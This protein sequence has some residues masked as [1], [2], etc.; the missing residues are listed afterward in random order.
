MNLRAASTATPAKV[1]PT[2][3]SRATVWRIFRRLLDGGYLRSSGPDTLLGRVT[4]EHAQR[5]MPKEAEPW[6]RRKIAKLRRLVK[7]VESRQLET[8]LAT[9]EIFPRSLLSEYHG[10]VPKSV[11]TQFIS[12][13]QLKAKIQSVFNDDCV[14]GS[15]DLFAENI[16]AFGGADFQTRFNE[17]TNA[18]TA[19]LS[20]LEMLSR[21]VAARA[22]RQ[23]LG[24][25][26]NWPEPEQ[27]E[28]DGDLA[29]RAI[30]RLFQAVLFR[31]PTASERQQAVQLLRNINEMETLIS[32]RDSELAFELSVTDPET[33]LQSRQTI[34]IRVNGDRTGLTQS[35]IDQRLTSTD[36]SWVWNRVFRPLVTQLANRIL[37][38]DKASTLAHRDIGRV[39]LGRD[40]AARLVIHNKGTLRN[41]SFAGVEL[42]SAGGFGPQ[43]I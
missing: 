42:L 24:P 30:D 38:A 26:E 14:R 3:Y 6:N 18:T 43:N 10:E 15:R 17:S 29:S 4:S 37:P 40:E 31:A 36:K 32:E 8:G 27:A 11:S 19:Y 22:Y 16:A 13:R 21:D 12:Y 1:R 2:S 34:T 28:L 41:V 23:R 7:F 5:R 35:L 39:Q 33:S 20:A 25:F 9:D